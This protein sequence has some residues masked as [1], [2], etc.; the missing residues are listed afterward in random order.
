MGGGI[1]YIDVDASRDTAMARQYQIQAVPTIILLDSG[2]KIVKTFV[3]TPGENELRTAMREA[4]G[5]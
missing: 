1:A 4:M 3:G 2:G 5:G